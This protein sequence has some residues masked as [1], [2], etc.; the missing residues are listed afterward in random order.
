MSKTSYPSNAQI[1]TAECFGDPS[2]GIFPTT[3]FLSGDFTF[4][5]KEQE[6]EFCESL[7]QSFALITDEV[8]E[9]KINSRG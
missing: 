5:S 8:P 2:T 3:F 6:K 9:I 7:A 1:I 4:D